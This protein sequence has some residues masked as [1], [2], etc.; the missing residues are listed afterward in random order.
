ME[1]REIESL[2]R[3]WDIGHLISHK[4]A[5]KGVVNVNWILKTT[6]GRYVLRKVAQFTS[7]NDLKFGLDYLTYLRERGFPYRIPIPVGM[8]NGEF[9][10][11]FKGSRFWVYE[12]IEGK[13]VKQFGYRKL[14]ECARM[15]AIYHKIVESSG[16]NNGKSEEDVFRREAVLKELK[17]YRRQ[18]LKKDKQSR[19]DRIFLEESSTLIPLIRRLDGREYS[20]LPRYPLHRDINPENVLWKNRRLVGLIDFENVGAMIDTVVKDVSVVL[21]YACR[22]RKQKHKLDLK[23]AEFFLREYRKHHQLSD[24]EIEFL[25]DIITTGAI[26][27]FAFAYWM[28]VN[29]PERAELY[30]LKLYSRTAQWYHRN[31]AEIV[32]KLM[33][34]KTRAS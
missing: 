34:R 14:E 2:L 32:N 23:R 8:K 30:R 10:L 12:F 25:P 24:A 31:K 29:D 3:N 7:T 20:T 5:R 9:I 1:K 4:Q 21:Q 6:E 27:D 16:L 22:D 17:E 28:L 18:I 11:R 13:D 26:E 15:M 33:N 19:R